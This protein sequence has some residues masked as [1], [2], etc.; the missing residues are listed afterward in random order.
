MQNAELPFRSKH[1]IILPER[2]HVTECIIRHLHEIEGHMGTTHILAVSRRTNWI[3]KGTTAV[4]RILQ[5]CIGWKVRS[6]KPCE[7]IMSTL[8]K[9]RVIPGAPFPVTGINFFCPFFIRQGR[10]SVKRYGCLFTCMKIRAVHIEVTA[11]LSTDGFLMAF[12]RF[13]NR[14][15]LPKIVLSDRGTNFVEAEYEL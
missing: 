7:Q 8:P 5:Q 3:L 4:K 2:H 10:M 9:E 15:G 12:T 13:V 11:D 14:R 6:A 1:P